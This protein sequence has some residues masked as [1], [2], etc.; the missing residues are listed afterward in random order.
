MIHR[1]KEETKVVE[2]APLELHDQNRVTNAENQRGTP[3][4]KYERVL[5]QLTEL[6]PGQEQALREQAY[7]QRET[8]PSGQEPAEAST[9]AAV[10]S[11][12]TIEERCE[13][14]QIEPEEESHEQRD[15]PEG[16]KNNKYLRKFESGAVRGFLWDNG[17]GRE[18][19][20]TLARIYKNQQSGEWSYSQSFRPRDAEDLTRVMREA[21]RAIEQ[22]KERQGDRGPA[23]KPDRDRDQERGR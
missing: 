16:G 1:E 20:F 7:H 15:S 19:T 18:A 21:A 17:S 6:L 23:R 22:V 4:K 10:A 13:D 5:R 2:A 8:N 3:M 11:G 12:T 9:K 14:M